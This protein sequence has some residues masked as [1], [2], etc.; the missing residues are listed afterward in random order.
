MKKKIKVFDGL[1]SHN[2]YS[3]L[4][5]DSDFLIWDVNPKE[6]NDGDIVF[7]TELDLD[8]VSLYKD[9][10]IKK[11]A[12]LLES[13][14]IMDQDKIFNYID[15]FDY[16]FTCR[17]DLLDKS[18]KFKFLPYWCTWIKSEEQK[19]YEKT[20][21]LSITASFKRQT[22]GHL[23]R[24][25][26]ISYFHKQMDIFGTGYNPVDNKLDTLKDYRFSI[27]IE[28]TR[29]NHYFSEKLLDC[30]TTG[31]IPIYWGCES[32]GD[33][34]NKK[35]I[36]TF[37]NLDELYLILKKLNTDYYNE[38]LPYVKENFEIVKKYKTPEDYLINYD[39]LK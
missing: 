31:T 12:W 10:N 5:C 25:V 23:F 21:N 15:D 22:E 28:N 29:K 9:K 38:L 18:A 35:G 1:F 39:I 27:V 6:I 32:I 2:P 3:C 36:I 34:F 30:F 17:E 7:F 14:A 16:I 4:N 13:P 11:C 37:N 20:K 26:V 33:F 8:K 24:H 19:I